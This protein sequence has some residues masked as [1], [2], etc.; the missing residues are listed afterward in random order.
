MGGEVKSKLTQ[1]PTKERGSRNFSTLPYVQQIRSLVILSRED[2]NM[3]G[4]KLLGKLKKRNILMTLWDQVWKEEQ[5]KRSIKKL[6]LNS[7]FTI[8]LDL[9]LIFQM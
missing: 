4:H 6:V 7:I 9:F 5:Q 2:H 1:L 3:Y 8:I